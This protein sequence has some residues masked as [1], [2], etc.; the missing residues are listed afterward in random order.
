[1]DWYDFISL[2]NKD[3]SGRIIH[4]WVYLDAT[5]TYG[6]AGE[7]ACDIDGVEVDACYPSVFRNS[8]EFRDIK[9]ILLCSYLVIHV[10]IF[11]QIAA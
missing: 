10:H 4:N 5:L 3:E 1:M 8:V 6:M 2:E 11:R 7:I 9:V